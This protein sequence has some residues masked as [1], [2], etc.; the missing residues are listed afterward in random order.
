MNYL[1]FI[2]IG[3]WALIGSALGF[4]SFTNTPRMCPIER[5]M[6]C[7]LSIG[8]GIFISLPIATYLTESQIFSKQLSLMLGGISAFGLPDFILKHWNSIIDKITNRAI[9]K[10]IGYSKYTELNNDKEDESVYRPHTYK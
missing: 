10:T 2:F 8:V 3:L 9:E 5:F 7:M 6:K 1:D 4:F